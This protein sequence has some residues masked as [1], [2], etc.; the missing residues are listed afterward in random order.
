MNYTFRTILVKPIDTHMRHC[1]VSHAMNQTGVCSPSA[2][3][4]C[5]RASAERGLSVLC[6]L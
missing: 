2:S 5:L 4:D 3:L 6:L 1:I